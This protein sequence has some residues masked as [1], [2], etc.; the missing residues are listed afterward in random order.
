MAILKG[1]EKLKETIREDL[2]DEESG[3][4]LKALNQA[5]EVIDKNKKEM[6]KLQELTYVQARNGKLFQST[7]LRCQVHC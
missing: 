2:V 1:E 4:D 7:L 3:S 5:T 6:A